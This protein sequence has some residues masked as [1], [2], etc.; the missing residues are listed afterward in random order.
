V[1]IVVDGGSASGPTPRLSKE[2]IGAIVAAA[3]KHSVQVIAHVSR[4][5][6]VEDALD[7]GVR[8]FAHMPSRD[9]LPQPIGFCA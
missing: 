7:G 1:K 2:T 6:E 9:L 5:E 3:R 4:A 8:L